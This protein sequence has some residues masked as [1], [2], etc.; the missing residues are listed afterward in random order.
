MGKTPEG[1]KVSR[2]EGLRTRKADSSSSKEILLSSG[3]F[4]PGPERTEGCPL[5][6]ERSTC[7]TH[8][9]N[10][11]LFILLFIYGCAGSL[12]LGSLSSSCPKRELLSSCD[13]RASHCGGF[14]Y[15]GARALGHAGFSSGIWAR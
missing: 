10:F 4:S 6:M 13:V 11:I 12:L 14:S 5:T 1:L 8:C 9:I 2:S 3:C 7:F 15:C